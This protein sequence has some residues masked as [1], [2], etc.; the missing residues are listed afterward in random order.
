MLACVALR[1]AD[2]VF[3]GL[4]RSIECLFNHEVVEHFSILHVSNQ[5]TRVNKKEES[6]LHAD[7][8]EKPVKVVANQLG[9]KNDY[10]ITNKEK[11]PLTRT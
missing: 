9:Q 2:Q 5:Q 3:D 1:K 7:F 4:S 6:G 8:T 11:A 10:P